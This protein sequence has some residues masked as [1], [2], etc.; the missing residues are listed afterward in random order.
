[1]AYGRGGP[2]ADTHTEE[3]STVLQCTAV[4]A[5]PQL[6]ALEALEE[7]EGGPDDA[8]SHLDHHEHL[9]CRLSEHDETTEHAAHLWTA[10][11]NPSRGLWLLWTGA[12]A[13]RVYR[14]AVFAE[15]P[16]VLHDVEQG[17][18]QWCG[19]PGDHALPHSF[20]VKDPLRDLLTERIRREAHRRPADDE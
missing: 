15:C 20:H 6:E 11:T 3:T 12:S 13:H 4:T 7:M 18:R 14:F 9:L 5:T 16:A 1:M 19:L 10:E 8:D 2:Y 17:S